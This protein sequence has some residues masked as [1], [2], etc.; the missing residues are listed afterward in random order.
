MGWRVLDGEGRVVG[1]QPPD[2]RDRGGTSFVLD[3]WG[4]V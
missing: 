2:L 3:W 4:E 1:R